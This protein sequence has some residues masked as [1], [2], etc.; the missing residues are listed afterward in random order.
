MLKNNPRC[1]SARSELKGSILVMGTDNAN[2]AESTSSA[3]LKQVVRRLIDDVMNAGRLDVLDELY[4][5]RLAPVARRW[6]EPFL[7]SFTEVHMRVVE[8]VAEDGTVVGRFA[9]S[10]THTGTW[11]GHAATGRRFTDVAEVYFFRIV[12]GRIT[13]AWE[14]EDTLTRLRQLGLAGPHRPP[15]KESA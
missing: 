5:S 3:D 6:V 9:C 12:D 2:A 4:D 8:L 10:G 13:R 11:L 14:L 1:L 7:G 15:A